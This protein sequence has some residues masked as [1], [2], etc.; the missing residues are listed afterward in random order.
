MQHFRKTTTLQEDFAK[1]GLL[2]LKPASQSL[3]E[4]K[5]LTSSDLKKLTSYYAK[6]HRQVKDAES[7]ALRIAKTLPSSAS[8]TDVTR[9][10]EMETAKEFEDE[11]KSESRNISK[12][13]LSEARLAVNQALMEKAKKKQPK[14]K[15]AKKEKKKGAKKWFMVQGKEQ[16]ATLS[17]SLKELEAEL[18]GSSKTVLI[19]AF[20]SVCKVSDTLRLRFDQTL[21]AMAEAEFDHVGDTKVF[22]KAEKAKS[23]VDVD[24]SDVEH[25]GDK[26]PFGDS[27][28]PSKDAPEADDSEYAHIGDDLKQMKEDAMNALEKLKK[29]VM[30]PADAESILKDMVAFL[31]GSMDSYMN[32]DGCDGMGQEHVGDEDPAEA[33]AEPV[34]PDSVDGEHVGDDVYDDAAPEP[35]G[36]ESEEEKEA[37][38]KLKSQFESRKARRPLKEETEANAEKMLQSIFNDLTAV[39]V[40]LGKTHAK[41]ALTKAAKKMVM[42]AKEAVRRARDLVEN[43]MEQVTQGVVDLDD[44]P[45]DAEP[46]PEAPSD[47]DVTEL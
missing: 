9:G 34:E 35:E 13:S 6:Y 31:G 5:V 20:E 42:E 24:D 21:L 44:V 37:K 7:L 19:R 23:E 15:A 32:I 27:E 33:G 29:D 1:L 46:N 18:S 12:V 3:N 16:V 30:T 14:K 28:K 11:P 47:A 26:K 10:M 41:G 22:D 38:A 45:A 2:D 39:N 43:A 8:L 4:S 25:V 17:E 40:D 36:E